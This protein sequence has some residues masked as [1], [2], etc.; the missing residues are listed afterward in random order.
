MELLL[1]QGRERTFLKWIDEHVEE[2]KKLLDGHYGISGIHYMLGVENQHSFKEVLDALKAIAPYREEKIMTAAQQLGREY[3]KKGLKE[4]KEK[5]LKEGKERGLKEGKE[6]GLKEGKERGL[7]EGKERGLKEGKE[8]GLKEGIQQEKWQIAKHMLE[9]NESKEKI[10]Q[11]TGLGWVE[12][13]ALM[14]EQEA[15]KE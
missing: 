4:G 2:I 15:T 5:G 8:R 11:F 13:E 7:K 10:H 6:R 9:F 12:I 14:R 3:E 1:K